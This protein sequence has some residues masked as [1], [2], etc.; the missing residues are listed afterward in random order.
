MN[1]WSVHQWVQPFL[2]TVGDYPAPGTPAWSRLPDDSRAKW[3][4]LLDFAR[5]HALRVETAQLAQAEAAKS[6]AASADWTHVARE[7]RARE[8]ARRAGVRIDRG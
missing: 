5:H 1:W 2:D 7:L 4:G 8:D 6:I 3:A